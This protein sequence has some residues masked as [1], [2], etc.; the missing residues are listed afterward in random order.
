MRRESDE[1]SA[2]VHE[3]GPYLQR[4]SASDLSV[5][6]PTCFRLSSL[7]ELNIQVART[8]E[9]TRGGETLSFQNVS[10]ISP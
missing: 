7:L 4:A 5:P 10:C 3:S 8:P 9:P 2:L 1:N 6:L